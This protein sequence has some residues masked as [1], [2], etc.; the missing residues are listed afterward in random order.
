MKSS[1]RNLTVTEYRLCNKLSPH[2]KESSNGRYS[3]TGPW[4]C[5]SQTA[6]YHS[7]ENRNKKL[8]FPYDWSFCNI[9]PRLL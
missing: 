9:T 7:P 4:V 6:V 5:T 3:N 2:K 1:N 8:F